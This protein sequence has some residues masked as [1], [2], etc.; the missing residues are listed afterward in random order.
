MIPARWGST[1]FP[2]KPL[3]KINGRPM[4]EIVASNAV[5]AFGKEKVVVVTDDKRIEEAADTLGVEVVRIDDDC[6]SGT[7]R[8]ALASLLFP[9]LDY[10][11]NLQGDEPLISAADIRFFVEETLSLSGKITN[12]YFKTVEEEVCSSVN[13]IK[14]MVSDSGRLVGASRLSVPSLADEKK[15]QACIYGMPVE[16][17]NW[18]QNTEKTASSIEAMEN[19]EILRFIEHG[20]EVFGI[21]LSKSHPVDTPEDISVVE[22]IE[23]S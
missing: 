14:M 4:I 23:N 19:I 6:P 15:I 10:V 13:R 18:F 21:E 22:S 2:G 20:F 16:N 9:D 17:L 11:F 7:D 5:D 12:G 1:R 8:V 3:A